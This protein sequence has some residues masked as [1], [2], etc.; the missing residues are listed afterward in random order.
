MQEP[1]G[2]DGTAAHNDSFAV[3]DGDR[4]RR[5]SPINFLSGFGIGTFVGVALALIAV[6]LVDGGSD[7]PSTVVTIEPD[8]PVL[9]GTVLATP[10]SRPRTRSALDVR[11]GPGDGFAIVGLLARGESVEVVGRDNDAMWLAIRFPPGSA[12]RGWIPVS[13]VDALSEL[14]R[15][16]VAL[17]TPLPRTIST[18]TAGDLGANGQG[19]DLGPT[20]VRTADPNATATVRPGLPD[21][22]VTAL[23]LL[24]DRRVAVT[25]ANRGPGDL[26]GFTVFVQIRNLAGRSEM[27]TAS[28][29]IFRVGSTITVESTTFDV[30]GIET[31]QATVD[32]FGSA[33]DADRGNNALQLELAVPIT[34][35]ATPQGPQ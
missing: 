18:F 14:A 30:S 27:V 9:N 4:Q 11:L 31:V 22:A 19:S 26:T 7:S 10:D 16:P 25:V 21:L 35:T 34:S 24:P 3:P 33:P 1:P 15:L 23:K 2:R 32:P 17:A 5:F 29:A 13:G 28:P 12:A 20:P 8:L 6:M